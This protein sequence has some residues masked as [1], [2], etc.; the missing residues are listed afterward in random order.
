MI[1]TIYI[2]IPVNPYLKPT[3]DEFGV[4]GQDRKNREIVS[5]QYG[6]TEK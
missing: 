4:D 1:V 6:I 2:L 3:L 5:P